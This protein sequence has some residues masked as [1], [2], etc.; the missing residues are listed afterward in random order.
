MKMITTTTAA[1]YHESSAGVAMQNDIEEYAQ[2]I[3]SCTDPN[4]V[5][6]LFG[7]CANDFPVEQTIALHKTSGVADKL[8]WAINKTYRHGYRKDG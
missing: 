7:Q 6:R 1:P 5:M 8:V 4:E 3:I 2:Q